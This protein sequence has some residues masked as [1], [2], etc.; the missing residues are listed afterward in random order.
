MSQVVASRKRNRK[1][2][3]PVNLVLDS[4]PERS[5]STLRAALSARVSEDTT[6]LYWQS[7]ARGAG[8]TGTDAF[9]CH[10]GRSV[11]TAMASLQDAAEASLA[12][13]RE[14]RMTLHAAVDARCDDLERSLQVAIS[15]KTAALERELVSI[16]AALELWRSKG[17]LIRV[18]TN[19]LTDGRCL[20]S[21][22]N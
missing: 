5:A 17:S 6:P 19:T 22:Q 2:S 11:S 8:T 7:I 21:T 20:Q 13:L 15:T 3:P 4:A 16:D 12:Q 10:L 1:G 9:I 14:T 18:E